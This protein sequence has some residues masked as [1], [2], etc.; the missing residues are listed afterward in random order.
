MDPT[1]ELALRLGAAVTLFAVFALWEVLAPRRPLA[2]GRLRRWPSNLG[3]VLVDAA[4]VRL[5]VPTATLGVALYAAGNGIGLFN[6]M[7]LRLSLGFLFGFVLLDLAIYL[8]HVAFHRVP[9][10]WRLHRM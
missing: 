3:I 8:Q 4:V 7:H 9:W 6:L 5:I 10:L 1:L 2:V